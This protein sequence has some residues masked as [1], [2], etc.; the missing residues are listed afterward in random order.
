ML[1][2]IT[3]ALTIG[4]SLLISPA[5]L[6]HCPAWTHEQAQQEIHTLSQHIAAWDH[7]YHSE[8][9]AT[10]A[11]ELYDQARAQLHTW[12]TCFTD[13]APPEPA[14]AALQ[15][16]RGSMDLPFSQMGLKKLSER[17][18][19]QWMSQR[20]ELWIQ[21][22]VDGVAVTLIYKNGVLQQML[23]RGNGLSGQNWLAHAQVIAAIP[24]QLPNA[25]A[26]VTLQG[27]LYLRQNQ[28]IQA[29]QGGNNARSQVAGLLNR[30][31]ISPTD[32]DKI[33]LLVWE[34][35]DGPATMPERLSQLQQ[36]GLPDSHK[37]SKPIATLTK[38]K[39]WREYWYHQPLPFASDGVVIKQSQRRINHPRSPYPPQ[40]AVALKYPL[41]QALSTITDV[42]FKI[43]RSGRIT[44]IVHLKAV[45][46]DDKTITKVSLGSLTRLKKLEL[47]VGDHVAIAL[48]GHA[49][50]QLQAVVWRSPQR[51]TI[52]PPIAQHYHAL[53]CWQNSPECQQQFL[54]RLTWL[55]HK[56]NLNMHGVGAHTWQA[57][58][59]ANYITQLTD[60]LALSATDLEQL[61]SFAQKRSTR[62]IHAFTQA[63][64][65]PFSLWLKALGAPPSI[66]PQA[67]DTWHTLAAL[68]ADDW[69][70]QRYLSRS[71]AQRAQAFF[72]HPDVQHAALTL[73]QHAV[74]GF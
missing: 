13:L 21:P 4:S 47:S 41:Q 33:G 12:R 23:S 52:Q 9:Q 65:K 20:D 54:A 46:L 27:E 34:W 2:F 49:I 17:E 19:Q 16:A 48:S 18:L 67:E 25:A 57:L 51:Q 55:G 45:S 71:N 63:K 5:V 58:I 10:I 44:P 8:G 61:P 36:L 74:D 70:Q 14:T 56:N 43:G 64:Y 35:P 3:I 72:Q 42:T 66:T 68:T 32:G 29:Q 7:S 15:T 1:R 28:H 60:W 22:K 11:D 50:P 69:Q 53:S 62:I 39:H 24:K 73:Q 38:A 30:T 59:A 37:F 40:W 6:A 26:Q 31:T